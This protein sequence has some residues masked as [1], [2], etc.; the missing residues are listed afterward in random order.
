MNQ[1]ESMNDFKL[2]LRV[3]YYAQALNYN[4]FYDKNKFRK[5]LYAI[6]FKKRDLKKIMVTK[7]ALCSGE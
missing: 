4:K 7:L 5:S 2:K 1:T 6:G 3:V